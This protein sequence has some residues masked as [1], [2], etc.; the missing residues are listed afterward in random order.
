MKII[1]PSSKIS[2]SNFKNTFMKTKAFLMICLFLGIGLTQL[3]AQKRNVQGEVTILGWPSPMDDIFNGKVQKVVVK[4]FWG[5]GSGNN[6]I[7][8]DMIT[9]KE[10][11]SLNWFYDFEA[12]F[13]KIGDHTIAL[14][15]LDD[16]AKPINTYQCIRENNRITLSKWS[17]GKDNYIAGFSYPKGDGY[18]KHIYDNKGYLISNDD[19][20]AEGDE[21]LYKYPMKNNVYGDQIECQV[22][23]SKG[24]FLSKWTTSYNEKRQIVGGDWAGK[25]GIVAGSFKNSYNDKGKVSEYTTYDKNN[26]VTGLYN[27]NYFESDA[28]GNW[29]KVIM[30]DSLGHIVFC[31]R[32]IT[33]F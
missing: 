21:L 11:D 1:T 3:P 6:I 28:K 31:E 8:G 25:D 27:Y 15:F 9:T 5:K 4:F 19:Y 33:Y 22:F 2:L 10:R 20:K 23:D 7:K 24:N 30:K 12:T 26:K 18:T 14:S 13:D 17:F 29:L 16:N 32:I